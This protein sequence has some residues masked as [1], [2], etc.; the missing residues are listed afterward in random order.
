MSLFVDCD[1]QD[2]LGPLHS[3][4]VEGGLGAHAAGEYPLS[5]RFGWVQH[6]FGASRQLNLVA[7]LNRVES[8]D[9]SDMAARS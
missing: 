5:P 2:E 9:A 3:K 7:P 6:R 8:S 4:L 1:R